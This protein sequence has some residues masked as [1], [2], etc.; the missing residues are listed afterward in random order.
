[1]V[2]RFNI[3]VLSYM[4]VYI[5]SI[6]KKLNVAFFSIVIVMGLS[7]IIGFINQ[8]SI[9]NKVDEAFNNRM[10][11]VK[12]IDQI[13]INIYKQGLYVRAIVLDN[14]QKYKDILDPTVEEVDD[15]IAQLEKYISAPEM[16]EKWT[17]M[18]EANN[19]FNNLFEDYKTAINTND[20]KTAKDIAVNDIADVNN[21][22]VT[23]ANEMS[24]YQ[25][26]QLNTIQ[27][28]TTSLI[29]STKWI[30]L[31]GLI[32]S[33]LLAVFFIRY[34]RLNII[35]PIGHVN[36]LVKVVANGDLTQPDIEQKSAD[37][38]GQLAESVNLMKNNLNSLV[39]NLQQNAEHLSASAEELSASTEEV[40]AT[41]EEIS[42]Q[43]THTAENAA[44]AS[45]ASNESSLAM[46]ETAQG[47]QR[48]AE[49]AQLL[50]ESAV[51][52]SQNST[53]GV[54]TVTK[55]AQQMETIHDSTDLVNDLV[56]K[57]SAQTAEIAK[58]TNVI[59]DITDQTNLLALNASI[60]A[61]RAGEHGKGFAVV[62][63]EVSKLA[64]QSKQSANAIKQLTAD[65]Q[66]DTDNVA[67]AVG[68]S[69][70]SVQ[71]GV[72]IIGEARQSFETISTSIE[73]MTAQIEDVSAT[74]EQ[75]S[76]GA[77]QVS[78]SIQNISAGS[79]QST[80]NIDVIV[81]AISEQMATMQQVT[82]VATDLSHNAQLL[83]DQIKTF[84]V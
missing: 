12:L 19:A 74:S 77:Q 43:V 33:V 41:N 27:T 23:I 47:V 50:N 57:L 80:Q 66:A 17:A 38:I 49:S 61:A 9:E 5:V 54:S 82:S 42:R 72:N 78:A 71:D 53:T 84:K 62:A 15:Q 20:A 75:L 46:E 39:R 4:G 58:I 30:T 76:A 37:E 22:L 29:S 63:D 79:S 31:G 69:L 59:T 48:I 45:V 26:K 11:Q 67:R 10:K 73:K 81:H 68:N 1:M 13:V 3:I 6:G 21:E 16:K 35:Q 14:D 65:I 28:D 51:H 36:K 24:D 40:T 34:I 70:D 64:E 83:Y 25:D 18:N 7:I 60:E 52:T 44:E 8:I 55:A 2:R 56:V 32:I